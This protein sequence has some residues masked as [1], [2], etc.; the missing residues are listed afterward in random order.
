VEVARAHPERADWEAVSDVVAAEGS[1][2][3][4]IID[5]LLLLARSDEGQLEAGTEP[6]DLDELVFGEAQRLSRSPTSPSTCTGHRGRVTGIPSSSAGWCAPGRQ[7]RTPRPLDR[8]VRGRHHD[9]VWSW[10]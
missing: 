7:C 8:C 1:R 6:V 3:E 5:E 10:R 2:L 4:R 9:G